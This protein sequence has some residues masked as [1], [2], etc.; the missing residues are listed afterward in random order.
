MDDQ[1][2]NGEVAVAIVAM[3]AVFITVTVIVTVVVWQIFATARARM[4]VAREEAYRKLAERNTEAIDRTN[5]YL[6]RQAAQV[7]DIQA[8]TAE[9]ERLLKE[10]G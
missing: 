3:V 7:A 9:L 8:R 10:V 6:E 1:I 5:A 2:S 4:S